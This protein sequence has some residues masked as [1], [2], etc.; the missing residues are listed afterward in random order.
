[1]VFP[2]DITKAECLAEIPRQAR[3]KTLAGYKEELERISTRDPLHPTS[4]QEKLLLWEM[5]WDCRVEH[6]CILPRI[7]DCVDY[8]LVDQVRALHHLLVC[9]PEIPLEHA[10]QLLDYA[11]SPHPLGM[12]GYIQI[13]TT[14]CTSTLCAASSR[15]ETRSWRCT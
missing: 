15:R 5:R 11:C 10:L 13:L 12:F 1:V 2:P 6:P 8:T 4:P 3:R 14:A 7:V 9:W